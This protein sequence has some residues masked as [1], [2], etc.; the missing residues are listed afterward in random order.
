MTGG[1]RRFTGGGA[2][3][4]CGGMRSERSRARGADAH[5]SSR[6]GASRLDRASRPVVEGVVLFE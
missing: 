2:G 5:R 4:S 1:A 6:P 3:I